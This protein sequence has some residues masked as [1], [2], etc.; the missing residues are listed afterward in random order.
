MVM[1]DT[2]RK[3]QMQYYPAPGIRERL[4][5]LQEREQRRVG[6]LYR[7]SLSGLINAILTDYLDRDEAKDRDDSA[8]ERAEA[9]AAL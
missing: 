4:E 5:A 6:H 1:T 8:S 2:G 7:V 3:P 9:T